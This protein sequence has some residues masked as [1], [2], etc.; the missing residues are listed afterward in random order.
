M[1]PTSPSL[2]G[3][4]VYQAIREELAAGG[5]VYIVCPLVSSTGSTSLDGDDTGNNATSVVTNNPANERRAVMDE[6]DRLTS[7]GVFGDHRVGLLH[8]RMS[9]DEKARAL[10]Q[11]SR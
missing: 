9:G 8:G 10:R 7:A 11:F 2:P 3:R 4:Q 1:E 5:R 6:F